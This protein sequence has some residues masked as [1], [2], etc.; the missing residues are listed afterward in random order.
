[1]GFEIVVRN[2]KIYIQKEE[3]ETKFRLIKNT[4]SF[5]CDAIFNKNV[6]LC[7]EFEI[8]KKFFQPYLSINVLL[9]LVSSL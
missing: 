4:S 3:D 8:K 2:K 1:M 5:L 7:L 6:K 9:V